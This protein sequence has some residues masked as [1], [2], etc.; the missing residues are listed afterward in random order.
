MNPWIRP[1]LFLSA[2]IGIS[3]LLLDGLSHR[4][5]PQLML[6]ND[7]QKPI[8]TEDPLAKNNIPIKNAIVSA[9][10]YLE[11]HQKIHRLSVPYNDMQMMPVISRILVKEGQII[12]KDALLVEFSSLEL[13]Q[14][15]YN[16]IQ[17]RIKSLHDQISLLEK[18]MSR[19]RELNRANA[20]SQS[21]LEK[22]ELI[23]IEAK[24]QLSEALSELELSKVR[25]NYS[26]LYSPINGQV[27]RIHSR[28][29]ERP[30]NNGI[31][32]V[33]DLRTMGV[34]LQVDEQNIKDVYIGQRAKIKSENGSFSGLLNGSV[35]HI[36]PVVSN[37]KRL[38]SDPRADNDNEARTI[39]VLV[40]L[41]PSSSIRVT[42][43]V[44]TKVIGFLQDNG[45]P[46]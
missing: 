36:Y 30:N 39:D 38:T 3:I 23:L 40:L 29:G 37:K 16:L 31:I 2:A 41:D 5:A 22:K 45:Q 10:G 32:E 1:T 35:S 19:Y 42:N 27:L 18:D 20:Y 13:A 44:G 9:P 33:A 4:S 6:E 28:I 26:R 21:E 17:A 46:R 11:P 43:L 34:T 14:A 25:I 12:N 7:K 24:A 15:S 8:G